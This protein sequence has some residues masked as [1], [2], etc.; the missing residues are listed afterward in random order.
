MRALLLLVYAVYLSVVLY[1]ILIAVLTAL[2]P[3]DSLSLTPLNASTTM[4]VLRSFDSQKL[5]WCPM[6]HSLELGGRRNHTSLGYLSRDV[7]ARYR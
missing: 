1:A 2:Y 4:A 6:V 7:F 3:G 5:K